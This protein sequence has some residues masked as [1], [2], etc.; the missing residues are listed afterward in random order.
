MNWNDFIERKNETKTWRDF[1]TNYMLSPFIYGVAFGLGHFVAY[2]IL[3]QNIF[4]KLRPH[5][6]LKLTY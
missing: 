5:A 4:V 1:I 3:E 6:R 2:L